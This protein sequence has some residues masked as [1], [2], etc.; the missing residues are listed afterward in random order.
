MVKAWFVLLFFC[1]R[2]WTS[3]PS[4]F[5]TATPLGLPWKAMSGN[6]LARRSAVRLGREM[7][8]DEFRK[9]L[10]K[11]RSAGAKLIWVG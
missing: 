9:L 10:I 6:L 2:L 1:L 5:E 3:Q 11:K 4:R 8:L 7:P